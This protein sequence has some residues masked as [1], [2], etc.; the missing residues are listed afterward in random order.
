M[1]VCCRP[2]SGLGGFVLFA[3]LSLAGVAPVK[4][5]EPSPQYL[6]DALADRITATQDWGVLGWNTAVKPANGP[7]AALRIKDKPYRHGLGHHA[8]GE[9]LVALEGQFKTFAAEVGVQWQG[10]R[11]AGS[12]VFQVYVDGKK[13]FDSGVVRENDPPREIRVSVAGADE[14]QLVAADAGDGIACDCADWAE[15]RLIPDPEAKDR[16]ARLAVDIA[17]FARVVTSDPKRTQ[18]TA[19]TRVQELPAEDVFLET[20]LLPA[21]DGSY[22]VPASAKGSGSIGLRWYEMRR[23]RRLELHW[24]DATAAP[25][26]DAVHLQYWVGV[27]PWQGQW[28]PLAAKLERS[29]DVWS[30][31]VAQKDQPTGTVRVRWLFP[32]STRPIVLK[33]ISAYSRSVWSTADLR[34]EWHAPA[35]AKPAAIVI[36]NGDLLTSAGQVALQTLKWDLARPAV[37]KVRYSQP[38]AAQGRPHRTAV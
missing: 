35:A 33:A 7:A 14:L 29:P 9:I 6:S 2:S 19:A 34:A 18:G 4:A 11:S 23:L 10:G 13:V 17:A 20:E 31:N 26:A 12:V 3:A 1:I 25:R 15:A 37:L 30:W 22:T 8:N 5:G 28:K 32:P 38:E 36:Y 21:A 16:L 27:S 24:A